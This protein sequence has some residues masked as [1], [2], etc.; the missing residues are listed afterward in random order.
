MLCA[1]SVLRELGR[2]TSEGGVPSGDLLGE[3]SV[4]G[5][6]HD[7]EECGCWPEGVLQED[8]G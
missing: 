8:R 1:G 6:I 5:G 7:L 4:V 2:V 3:R